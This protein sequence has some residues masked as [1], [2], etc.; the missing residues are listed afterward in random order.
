M[1]I[2][3]TILYTLL[4]FFVSPVVAAECDSIGDISEKINCYNKVLGKLG[5]TGKTLSSQISSFNAQIS[6]TTL[7]ISQ[8]ED[9]IGLL[10][11]RIVQLEGSLESLTDAFSQRAIET[12]KMARVGD[13]LLMIIS[14]EDLSEAV[15]RFFY[16]KKI[17]EADR[18]LLQRLQGAQNTYKGEKLDQEELQIQLE[19]QNVL[20]VN[21]KREKSN[22]LAVT[23]SNEGRY[24][25]LLKQAQ[26]ELRQ[27]ANSQFTGKKDVKKGDVV[28]VMGSTGNSTGPHL[29]FGYYNLTES[30]ANNLFKDGI[31]WYFSRNESPVSILQNRILHFEKLA[32]DDVPQAL[33]R[34]IGGGGLSWPM[35]NPRITQCYG[36]TPYSYG[37]SGNFHNGLD[38]SDRINTLVRAVDDGVAYSYRGSTSFGN[39]V[40][41]FHTNGK[42][43]LYLHLQ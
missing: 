32:C 19:E 35:S 14:S 2:F 37:Y 20:L 42:M 39:N 18:E 10:S 3:L 43:S 25:E 27:L 22:L 36:H 8:T 12:Y 29:H 1:K 4:Y 40:R 21:Q 28:G 31:G 17:Q 11:G 38:M 24:Q 34:S 6:L 33:D 16:L 26:D 7:K 30:E 13:P 15:S 5:N 41:I 23:K 9:K